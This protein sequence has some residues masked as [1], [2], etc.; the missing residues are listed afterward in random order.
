MAKKKSSF[1]MGDEFNGSGK[2]TYL[3]ATQHN[4]YAPLPQNNVRLTPN[5]NMFVPVAIGALPIGTKEE[6]TLEEGE[7]TI[8]ATGSISN[9]LQVVVEVAQEAKKC[10]VSFNARKIALTTGSYFYPNTTPKPKTEED[11]V[12]GILPEETIVPGKMVFGGKEYIIQI[13]GNIP[14][15]YSTQEFDASKEV[16]CPEWVGGF[17]ASA[18]LTFGIGHSIKTEEEF[19]DIKEFIADNR[20]DESKMQQ[21]IDALFKEDIERSIDRVNNFCDP[22]IYLTQNQFDAVVILQY[23]CEFSMQGSDLGNELER[24]R[25]ER[26]PVFDENNI[27]IGFTYTLYKGKR[28]KGLVTRRNNELNLF[29]NADYTYYDSKEKVQEKNIVYIS[30]P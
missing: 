8:K 19:N 24:H 20:K 15:I 17:D 4:T 29:F 18:D 9:V 13:E 12:E 14:Y 23:N 2:K 7:G 3:R 5:F 21:K 28:S 25:G 22:D 27:I 1:H 16:A 30:Y 10:Q 26:N 11:I 6:T